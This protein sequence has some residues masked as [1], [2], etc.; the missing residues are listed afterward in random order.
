MN[1]RILLDHDLEGRKIFLEAGLKETGWDQYLTFEFI[2]LRDLNLSEESTDQQIWSF[3][4]RER[5]VFITNNRNRDDATSLQATI[6]IENTSTSLPVLTI[7]DQNKLLLAEYRQQV[8]D[9]LATII[10]DLE[11]YLGVGRIYLP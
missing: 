10:I 11:S 1:L 6:E 8:A 3:V 4:Q 7:S 5:L 2:R 9:S